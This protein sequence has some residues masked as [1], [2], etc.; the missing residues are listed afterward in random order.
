LA[1]DV[2]PLGPIRS[3]RLPDA[4]LMSIFKATLVASGGHPAVKIRI[5]QGKAWAAGY[6]RVICPEAPF[7]GDGGTMRRIPKPG[8]RYELTLYS[9]AASLWYLATQRGIN[10][11]QDFHNMWTFSEAPPPG[12]AAATHLKIVYKPTFSEAEYRYDG[13]SHT[14]RRF[15]VGQPTVDELTGQQIAPSNVL[16]LYVNH[17]NSDILADNHDP[18]HP[19]YAVS[20]Q[21]WGNGSARL[22][23]DGR[24]YDVK[25][26]RED[27]QQGGDRL[28]ILDDQGKQ[29]P[30][31][32]G[33][34]W[35][36]LVRMDANV[37]ID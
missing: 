5:T 13:G 4:E 7:L 18:N 27:A 34:T 26:V 19:W 37:Q 35:I 24:V 20:I 30:L 6:K 16:V 14:Y 21:L 25:W 10:Q 36:Q 2:N 28:L 9:D 12:G 17:V 33:P 29:V 23:R 22:M 15:D 11:R 1:N 32:P 31:R 3:L 8:R